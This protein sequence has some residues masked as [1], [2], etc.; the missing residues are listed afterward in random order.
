MAYPGET[1]K[2]GCPCD[3]FDG[4]RGI[5]YSQSF[6]VISCFDSDRPFNSLS[7]TYG[8][9]TIRASIDGKLDELE[10]DPLKHKRTD[11]SFT[12]GGPGG[13]GRGMNP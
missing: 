10:P 8:G 3:S 6:F 13:K 4:I 2:R 1:G 11:P 5:V 9:K 12:E 7:F